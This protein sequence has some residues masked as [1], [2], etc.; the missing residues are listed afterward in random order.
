MLSR[1]TFQLEYLYDV[2][3]INL[4]KDFLRKVLVK[5]EG[6]TLMWQFRKS[7]SVLSFSVTYDAEHA[8]A[9]LSHSVH[10]HAH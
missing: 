2:R 8:E 10:L 7:F 4:L 9:V 6:R 3:V 1:I 5:C